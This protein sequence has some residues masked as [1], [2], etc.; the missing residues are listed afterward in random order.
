ML[1]GKSRNHPYVHVLAILH[2]Q[3]FFGG[4]VVCF[5]FKISYL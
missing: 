4:Q 5:E 2:A 1:Q 3:I